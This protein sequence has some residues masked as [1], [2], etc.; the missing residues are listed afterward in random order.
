MRKKL[1]LVLTG[2]VIGVIAFYSLR[3]GSSVNIDS[4]LFPAMHLLAYFG[5]AG[6]FLLHF[7]DTRKGHFLA[8]G[9]AFSFSLLMEFLQIPVAGRSFSLYD[10]TVNLLGSSLVILD[11]RSSLITELIEL[12]DRLIQRAFY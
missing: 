7:H 6:S 1:N 4:S 10:I 3:P 8:A 11:H 12:E 2:T 9:L 5:L